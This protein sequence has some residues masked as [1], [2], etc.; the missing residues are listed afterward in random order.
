[1]LDFLK[2]SWLVPGIPFAGSL[3]I[4]L[5][6]V[7]FSRTVNRLTKPVSFFL[8]ICIGLSTILSSILYL[9]HISGSSF[10]LGIN[11]FNLGY[12]LNFYIDKQSSISSLFVELIFLIIMTFSFKSLARKNGYVRYFIGL[13]VLC[14]S[15]LTF[16]LSGDSFHAFID[17]LLTKA[18]QIV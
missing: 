3:L 9:K 8:I 11:V 13:G 2:L 6:L 18:A 16:I 17:P 4:G 15:A 10:D 7:S 5:L 14:G 12:T 1:M